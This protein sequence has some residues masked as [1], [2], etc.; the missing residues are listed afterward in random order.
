M[1][2]SS[3]N[4]HRCRID[5]F[6]I[7]IPRVGS[8]RCD[9]RRRGAEQWAGRRREFRTE[10]TRFAQKFYCCNEG[11]L[12]E[13]SQQR[14]RDLPEKREES[15]AVEDRTRDS[16]RATGDKDWMRDPL[17]ATGDVGR[18]RNLL[19]ATGDTLAKRKLTRF[20]E[21]TNEGQ[22]GS[23]AGSKGGREAEIDL[24]PKPGLRRFGRRKGEFSRE[25]SPF[26]F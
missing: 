9:Y 18:I 17:R 24:V 4:R 16:L 21:R 10:S 25:N 26:G 8:E 14:K 6:A 5:F 7:R 20:A 13:D 23:P 2:S 12:C 15:E 11:I 22:A 3:K 19:R 1:L